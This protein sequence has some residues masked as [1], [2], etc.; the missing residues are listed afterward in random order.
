M[1]CMCG[2]TPR[3]EL[4]WFCFGGRLSIERGG[5]VPQVSTQVPVKSLDT[6]GTLYKSSITTLSGKISNVGTLII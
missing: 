6:T 1:R 2:V 5:L 4:L 3:D